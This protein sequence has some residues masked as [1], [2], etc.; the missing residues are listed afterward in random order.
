MNCAWPDNWPK[1]QR[2][3][4]QSDDASRV[5]LKEFSRRLG[6]FSRCLIKTPIS[7]VQATQVLVQIEPLLALMSEI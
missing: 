1:V 4:L 7:V 2:G 3:P 6:T 5:P